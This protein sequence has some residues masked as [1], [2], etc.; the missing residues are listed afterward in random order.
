[1]KLV[2][3]A[4]VLLIAVFATLFCVS[5]APTAISGN[6]IGDVINVAINAQLKLNNTVN[7]DIVAVL[8]ALLNQ[9]RVG[10]DAFDQKPSNAA[11]SPKSLELINKLLSK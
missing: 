9:Q 10:I 2:V 8:I 3:F 5:A 6:N 1:M 4:T 11:I 7:Q